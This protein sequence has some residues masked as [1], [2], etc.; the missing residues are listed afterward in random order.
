MTF[1]VQRIPA[2]RP[3]QPALAADTSPHGR[4]ECAFAGA[5]TN[6]VLKK[7][8]EELRGQGGGSRMSEFTTCI[9]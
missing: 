7:Q 4:A 8:V 9:R 1:L 6:A 3:A 2:A 5:P